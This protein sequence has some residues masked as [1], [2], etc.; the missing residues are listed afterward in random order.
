MVMTFLRSRSRQKSRREPPRTRGGRRHR[1]RQLLCE[2]LE[3][4]RL[5]AGQVS[6]G[7]GWVLNGGGLQDSHT[8]LVWSTEFPV[9][10]GWSYSYANTQVQNLTEGGQTDW[11]LPSKAELEEAMSHGLENHH[12]EIDTYWH[13][14]ST[15]GKNNKEHWL[16]NNA[17]ASTT[18]SNGAAMRALAVRGSRDPVTYTT[19]HVRVFS[20]SMVTEENALNNA[21]EF[22]VSNWLTVS[23]DTAPSSNVV[24]PMHV[25]DP[26][27][28]LLSMSGASQG[29]S[30]SLT[31]TPDNWNI[32]QWVGVAGVDD[33]QI[34]GDVS[35]HIILNPAVSDDP[36]Y[37][38]MNPADVSVS[39]RDNEAAFVIVTPTSGL[40]TTET[41]G[42][43]SFGVKLYSPPN[44]DVFVDLASS[45]SSEGL[46]S[47]RGEPATNT[48]T[49][50]FTTEN[51]DAVQTVTVLGQDDSLTDGETPYA[52]QLTIGAGS[53]WEFFDLIYRDPDD[54]SITNLDDEVQAVHDYSSGT[55]NRS[56]PDPGTVS[57]SITVTDSF[58]IDDVNAT[59]NIKHPYDSD[60]TVFLKGPDGTRIN[61]FTRVGGSGDNFSGTILDDEA[62]LAI[63][64]GSAP[65]SGSFRPAES[66]GVFDG[67]NVHGTWTLEIT[68]SVRRDKGTLLNWTLTVTERPA[69]LPLL[70]EAAHVENGASALSLADVTPIL[71]AATER[72]QLAG[73][74][75]APLSNIQIRIADLGGRTLGLASG[76]TIW[77]DDDAAGW[78]WFVDQT[79]R[80]DSEFTLMG[81]QGEQDRMD[82]LS[83]VMHEL[84]HLFDFAHDEHG[85]MAETL[86]AGARRTD[87]GHDDAEPVDD[88]FHA[89][90]SAP[91]GNW[92]GLWMSEKLES[93]RPWAKWRR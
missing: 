16:V 29:P 18:F 81:D 55:L 19:P 65:F 74:T 59:L 69:V 1:H 67:K 46:I 5:L 26:T 48:A 71:A 76:N 58:I 92:L 63:T 79:P 72:W 9:Q 68:D 21:S 35:Y 8:G 73:I 44:G 91:A 23:L 87:L 17:G 66:L 15:A 75:A 78:G 11:R 53:S 36:D 77:L 12:G 49:L 45:D 10:E 62:S 89:T 7:D 20:T 32:P 22:P 84:G 56:I 37:N 30:I 42:T 82:L 50:I 27:E 6:V 24:V 85:L 31:F 33:A 14:T 54:V 61:L 4:R 64:S 83:V 43:A 52:I 3:D 34:D 41:G 88:V 86:A 2:T 28:G 25:N 80:D 40:V 47:V 70:A 39:N 90:G 38:G 93:R 51:W 60:L 13:W 57:V